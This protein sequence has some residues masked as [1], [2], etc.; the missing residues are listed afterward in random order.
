[1]DAGL[2]SILANNIEVA[3]DFERSNFAHGTVSA[4]PFYS[5]PGNASSAPSGSL[6]KLQISANTSG[7]TLPP[8]TALSRI[9]YQSCTLNGSIV[10]ASAYILWPYSPR[11]EH[12]GYAV[13]GWAHGTSGGFGDCAPSHLRNLW[14]QFTAPFTLALQGY[15]VVAPDYA[16]LGVDHDLNGNTIRH[17]YVANPAHANDLFFSVQAAQTAFTSL[18]KRFVLVGHSQGGGAAWA[19]AQR[20]A[21]KPVQGYLGA[22]AGSP[23]TNVHDLIATSGISAGAVGML[24]AN[25]LPDIFPS[26][27]A[28]DIL[29][30]AG[31][32]LYA[33]L[34]EIQGCNSVVSVS[35]LRPELFQPAWYDS[36]YAK[37]FFSLTTNGGQ[38]IAGPLLVLHGEG[39]PQIPVSIT[40]DAVNITCHLYP[41][42]QLQY[43]TYPGVG[44]TA[45][46]YASQVTW[47]DWIADRFAG[48]P[49]AA[50]CQTSRIASSRPYSEYQ[51]NPNW[52]IEFATAPYET[53]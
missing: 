21:S 40:S 11:L 45:V 23:V 19:A 47:L 18:S 38:S 39:D 28:S 53:A 7:Y 20:Q 52:F 2:D 5:L 9:L 26:F 16:G 4:D 14:Y 32:A 13:V 12:D 50:G 27:N 17:P 42:S 51:I 36:L 1:M 24:L 44:H 10:P 6:L 37:L 22:I 49:L 8:N 33:L 41:Q 46:M 30:P 3:L 35:F 48:K 29:T 25:A 34:S 43:L 15:V 31:L